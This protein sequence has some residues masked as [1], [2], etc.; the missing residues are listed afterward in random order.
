MPS[1]RAC[2]YWRARPCRNDIAVG[3]PGRRD[4]V[5]QRAHLPSIDRRPAHGFRPKPNLSNNRFETPGATAE[6]IYLKAWRLNVLWLITFYGLIVLNVSDKPNLL[7]DG[8]RGNPI[9]V[10]FGI[11][12]AIQKNSMS[13]CLDW[14][15]L[16]TDLRKTEIE[17]YDEHLPQG[18]KKV[19][20]ASGPI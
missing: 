19:H 12:H 8:I 20:R 7:P 17:P 11:W 2:S 15:T 18:L 4:S 9:I 5:S 3:G 1:W 6:E 16:F 14:I 10:L 13:S